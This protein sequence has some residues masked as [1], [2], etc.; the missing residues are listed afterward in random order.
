MLVVA[1]GGGAWSSPM[2][3]RRRKLTNRTTSREA[4]PS[5]RERRRQQH[6]GA[7]RNGARRTKARDGHRAQ[8]RGWD[9]ARRDA[10]R[11]WAAPRSGETAC[12]GWTVQLTVMS[13]ARRELGISRLSQC[14]DRGESMDGVGPSLVV[15]PVAA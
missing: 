7:A 10:T 1:V 4:P 15:G 13:E 12:S 8:G 11:D 6:H 5:A 9:G 2:R 3:Q 14:R